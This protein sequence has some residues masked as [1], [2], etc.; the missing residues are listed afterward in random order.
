[1]ERTVGDEMRMINWTGTTH[2]TEIVCFTRLLN[3]L[4]YF[5]FFANDGRFRKTFI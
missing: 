5:C 3:V 1:M 4:I 2:L